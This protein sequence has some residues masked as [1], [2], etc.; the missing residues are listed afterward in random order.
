M[1]DAKNN[2]SCETIVLEVFGGEKLYLLLSS[3]LSLLSSTFGFSFCLLGFSLLH[4]PLSLSLLFLSLL[5]LF[6]IQHSIGKVISFFLIMRVLRMA[7][8]EK[9]EDERREV[10]RKACCFCFGF[11]LVGSFCWAN[12]VGF[13]K[14]G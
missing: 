6:S 10:E 12:I 9:E 2:V 8:W 13:A 7:C 1:G 5:H 14:I 11:L 3:F 4:S